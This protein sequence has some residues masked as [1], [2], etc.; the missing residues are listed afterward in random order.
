LKL[1]NLLLGSAL[2]SSTLF[3]GGDI[4]PVEPIVVEETL[5][6]EW[7]FYATINGW[8]PG[9][10][11]DMRNGANVNISI[12]DILDNLNLGAMSTLGAQKGKWGLLTDVIYL[13]MSQGVFIPLKP[14]L[15]ITDI[16]MKAWIV[17]PMVTYRFLEEDQWTLDL[18]G[19]ARYLDIQM[20]LRF[21]YI[22]N[23]TDSS[24]DLWDAVV[25]IRGNYAVDEKWF[26]PFHFDVGGGDTDLTWQAYAGVGYKY[27]NFDVVAG[28]RYLDWQF[29]KSGT[30]GR[31]IDVLT[32]DGPIL[33]IKFYF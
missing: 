10:S 20:P 30:G 16:Q 4:V 25:G 31:V 15:A 32:V 5:S 3:A 29:D 23:K 12:R 14:S 2:L 28:Y 9:M 22:A 26:V 13:D 33:G 19:G 18:M 8:A 24:F 6:T 27:E 21:N 17:T 7:E 11:V 1:T